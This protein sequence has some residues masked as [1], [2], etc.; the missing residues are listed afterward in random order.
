MNTFLL[1]FVFDFVQ[2]TLVTG[3]WSAFCSTCGQLRACSFLLSGS[4]VST[5]LFLSCIFPGAALELYGCCRISKLQSFM[6]CL[7]CIFLL[8]PQLYWICVLGCAKTHD[9]FLHWIYIFFLGMQLPGRYTFSKKFHLRN[10]D[11]QNKIWK[12]SGKLIF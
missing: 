3:T 9:L 6:E 5:H 1:V 11:F 12:Y 7:F 10:K 4:A 2:M 8:Y